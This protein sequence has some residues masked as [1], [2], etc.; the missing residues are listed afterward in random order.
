[1]RVARVPRFWL[2]GLRGRSSPVAI[3]WENLTTGR[4][5]SEFGSSSDRR[6]WTLFQQT[7]IETIFFSRTLHMVN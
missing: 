4:F 5:S 2:V 1:M 6:M 3:T 7:E